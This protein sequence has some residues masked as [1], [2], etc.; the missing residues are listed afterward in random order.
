[1]SSATDLI[2]EHLREAQ[3]TEQASLSLLEGHLRGAPPGPYRSA[4][5][6]HVDETRRHAHQVAE[7]LTSLGA[8]RGPV[9]TVLTLGEAIAGR[10][11][12]AALAPLHLFAGR[13]RPDVLL[14]NVHDEIA[15]EAREVAVYDALERLAEAAGDPTTA[16]LARAIREDEERFLDALRA[17]VEPLADRVARERLGGARPQATPAPRP[18]EAAPSEDEPKPA[19][20]HNGGPVH[21]EAETPYADRAAR[22]REARREAGHTREGPT[23][24]Q[25][26]RLREEQREA[27]TPVES[28]G[29][30]APAAQVHIEAPWEGYDTLKAGEIVARLRDANDA[31]RAMVRLYEETHKNRKSILQATEGP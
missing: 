23:R 24:A 25:A 28:E 4:A 11:A 19:G 10:L 6:R 17:L 15:A 7:R 21:T 8:T 1:M 14:R 5:R 30:G 22:R 2:T 3:A 20:K 9:G 16:S 31:V 18:P 29:A 12:G 27:E 13:T 26:A